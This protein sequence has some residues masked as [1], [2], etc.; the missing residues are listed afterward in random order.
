MKEKYL[1]SQNGSPLRAGLCVYSQCC[2]CSL[3]AK[4]SLTI[5]CGPMDCPWISQATTLEWVAISLSRG[6][7]RPT[8]QTQVSCLAG[9]FFT[10][11]PPG[12][13]IHTAQNRKNQSH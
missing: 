8:D 9:G 6:S 13:T 2:Y 1:I 12:K 10:T 5:F 11:E 7:S 4:S 3:V